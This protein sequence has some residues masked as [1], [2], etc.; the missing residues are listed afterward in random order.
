MSRRMAKNEKS[1]WKRVT[2]EGMVLSSL[3]AY[4]FIGAPGVRAQDAGA[5]PAATQPAQNQQ[6]AAQAQEN[7]ANVSGSDT[8]ASAIQPAQNPK[9]HTS[10]AVGVG[11]KASLL[12]IGVEAA[13]P[14]TRRTNLRV[15]YNQFNYSRTFDSNGITYGGK[16]DF[17]SL[18]VLYDWF[19]FGGSFHLS[20]GL[21]AYNGN[22]V[23]A[24]ASVPGG[25]TFTLNSTTYTS[26]P[27]NPITGTGKLLMGHKAAPMFLFG[28]GNL[29]PRRGHFSVSFE[30]GAA[31]TGAPSTTLNLSGNA[32]DSFGICASA[33]SNPKVQSDVQAEQAKLNHDV[34][35]FKVFPVLSLGF[36]YKF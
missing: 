3:V 16:F 21:L 32:C 25:Q 13:A 19:P 11:I 14:V 31:F 26:D 20:P 33:S 28:F 22:Q 1:K 24:N 9:Q 23:K 35:P 34:S 36:G 2:V 5:Q 27:S 15:G 4:G 8:S 17:R 6:A 30:I 18:D 7:S 10:F 12:G 29:A